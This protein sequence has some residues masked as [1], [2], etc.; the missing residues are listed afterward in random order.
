LH[1]A[2]ISSDAPCPPDPGRGKRNPNWAYFKCDLWHSW[3]ERLRRI[4]KPAQ[5]TG[6]N[7]IAILHETVF[8]TLSGLYPFLNLIGI[9]EES[10]MFSVHCV[11]LNGNPTNGLTRFDAGTHVSAGNG[12][13]RIV[14]AALFHIEVLVINIQITQ[15]IL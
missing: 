7:G 13:G 2:D 5:P 3:E 6:G 14:P 1:A 15:Y 8:L 4:Q 10:I 11:T 9:P 12:S